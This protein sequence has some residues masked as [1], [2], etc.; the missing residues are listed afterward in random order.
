MRHG[1][2][3]ERWKKDDHQKMER[4]HHKG[5]FIQNTAGC[6]KSLSKD[7]CVGVCGRPVT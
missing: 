2:N 6:V 1:E 7:V 4:F 3:S 5:L